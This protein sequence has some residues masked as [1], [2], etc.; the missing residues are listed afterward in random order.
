MRALLT[1]L[2]FSGWMSVSGQ[3]RPCEAPAQ[4]VGSLSMTAADG[5]ISSAASYSYDARAQ[6]IRFR[7]HMTVF[8]ETVQMDLLMHFKQGVLYELDS[9][10]LW[11]EKKV[12][13]SPFHPTRVPADALFMGQ[14]ILG[15]TSVP[16]LGL[17]TNSW[18][19]E[20]PEIQ[21]QY[22]LT[23]T[24]FTCLPVSA[25]VFTPQTGWITMSFYNHL[26]GVHNPQDFIPPFFC[27][28][29][30]PNERLPKTNFLK[31]IRPAH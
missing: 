7:N 23:F 25:S 21:A 15:T 19:G 18:V 2:F 9:S 27:P 29:G 20:I 5:I 1:V 28:A 24:E 22:M 30:P 16:G 8:N 4:Y 12:L 13:D 11:C 31:A 3:P 17:L 26:L 10:R 14:V 6:Q